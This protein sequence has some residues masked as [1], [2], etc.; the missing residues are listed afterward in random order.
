M[1]YQYKDYESSQNIN[2]LMIITRSRVKR[3]VSSILAIPPSNLYLYCISRIIYIHIHLHFM[4]IFKTHKIQNT[5][6]NWTGIGLFYRLGATNTLLKY[7]YCL[8]LLLTIR[9]TAR[10]HTPTTCVLY[11]YIYDVF[12]MQWIILHLMSRFL[13]WYLLKYN[14]WTNGRNVR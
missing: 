8:I 3:G 12:T 5:I 6:H 14:K 13:S 1:K 2:I 10:T 11:I 7:I 9:T 4:Y